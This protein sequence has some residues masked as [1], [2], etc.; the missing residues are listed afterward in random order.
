MHPDAP[1][2]A[3][4]PGRPWNSR[5]ELERPLSPTSRRASAWCG[6]LTATARTRC[7]SAARSS[8]IPPKPGSTSAKPPIRRTATIST[9]GRPEPSPIRGRVSRRKSV[10]AAPGQPFLPAIRHLHQYADQSQAHL[11]GAMERH[12]PAPVRQGLG[13]VR[14]ATWATRPPTCGSREES[15]SRRVYSG[16]CSAGAYVDGVRDAVLHHQATPI[17]AGSCTWPT[18]SAA[19]YYASIDTMDD[20]A[21]A[22]YKGLLLS[23]A[24][25]LRQQLHVQLPTTPIRIACPTTISA[26]RW[27]ARPTR[28]P[29]TAM[30]I[31]VRAF[32]TRAT[33]STLRWWH[34]LLEQRQRVGQPPAERLATCAAV[35]P[36]AA[37]SL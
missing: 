33:T 19:A 9:S 15:E 8:T 29:S 36:R 1:R 12:L 10:P 27:P 24:A 23:D 26:R 28:S 14:S 21:V 34:Q 16:N 2:R 30:P 35:S 20:G 25:S 37:A 7:A 4:L 11:R 22:R 3:V 17:S 6:I 5:R 31:G 13:G 32:P 18:P